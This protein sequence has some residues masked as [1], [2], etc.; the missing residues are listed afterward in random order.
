MGI[1]TEKG[2]LPFG[3]EGKDGVR[4]RDFEMRPR[5]VKDTL[6]ISREQGMQKLEDDDMFFTLCLTAKQIIH[7]GDIRP[8]PVE[9][10]L[11][12]MDEDMAA[13]LDA[14][15]ALA[16]RLESFRASI[17]GGGGQGA[18]DVATAANTPNE[19]NHPGVAKDTA[20]DG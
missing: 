19:E 12:M 18:S 2:T 7:I 14:K 11:E 3:V 20:S 5:L 15:E 6:E 16:T 8:V 4:H 1:I 13:I 17:E 10:M 9:L